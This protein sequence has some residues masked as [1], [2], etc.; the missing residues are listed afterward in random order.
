M[1]M[2]IPTIQMITTSADDC[3]VF[4]HRRCGVFDPHICI[5]RMFRLA[6]RLKPGLFGVDHFVFFPVALFCLL[7]HR[8][9]CII[10]TIIH[11]R[12]N[13]GMNPR[14]SPRTNPEK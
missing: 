9:R 3:S 12:K 4:L 14:K 5:S 10:D 13:I 7:L 1:P 6:F 2:A 8:F 11:T